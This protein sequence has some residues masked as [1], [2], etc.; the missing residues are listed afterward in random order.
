MTS[1]PPRYCCDELERLRVEVKYLRASSAHWAAECDRKHARAKQLQGALAQAWADGC[2]K[3]I[4]WSTCEDPCD[5]RIPSVYE[6][7]PYRKGG[8]DE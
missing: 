3:G 2:A 6:R 5:G 8:G 4:D 7:N 1:A